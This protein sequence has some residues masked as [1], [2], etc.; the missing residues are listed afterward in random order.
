M[1]QGYTNNL[2]NAP[3]P[4]GRNASGCSQRVN[5]L[6]KSLKNDMDA[7]KNGMPV[8]DTKV[9]G[10]ITKGKNKRKAGDGEDGEIDMPKKRRRTKKVAEPKVKVKQEATPDTEGIG[11][12]EQI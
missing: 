12:D 5:R 11:E 3:V 9:K 10:N 7:L 1:E 6:K 8:S 4:V 2:Q